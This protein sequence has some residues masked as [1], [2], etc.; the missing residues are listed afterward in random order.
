MTIACNHF[1][2]FLEQQPNGP[3][4]AAVA[5]HLQECSNCRAVW[6]DLGLIQEAG[7][8]LGEEAP[9]P[10]PS[11]WL[12]LREQLETEGLIREQAAPLREESRGGWLG[13]FLR[14][15]PA[16][17]GAYCSA[18]LLAAVLLVYVQFAPISQTAVPAPGRF[19]P[20]ANVAVSLDKTLDGDLERVMAS[21]PAHNPLLAN[22]L[23][24]NL[25]IVDNLIA[26]CEQSVR[27]QPENAMAREYLYRAYQQKAVLLATAMDRST[28]EDR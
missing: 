21:L 8:R 15:R 3:L 11:I 22:S 5:V 16:L 18:L 9:E 7:R 27:E 17:A 12:N 20:S 14:L 24:Q 23:R 10:P 6:E 13:G 4:S 2:D 28:L 25:G 1:H 19:T 26:V